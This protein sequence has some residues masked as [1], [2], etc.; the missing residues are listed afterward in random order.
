MPD[1]TA[2]LNVT[3]LGVETVDAE[4]DVLVAE[5]MGRTA[6]L[7]LWVADGRDKALCFD[8]LVTAQVLGTADLD[9]SILDPV[10][11]KSLSP[12]TSVLIAEERSC[13]ST[14]DIAIDTGVQASL[15]VLLVATSSRASDLDVYL[16]SPD[17]GL[18]VSAVFSRD[19]D[20]VRVSLT[21]DDL[22]VARPELLQSLIATL[23]FRDQPQGSVTI[24]PQHVD[25]QGIYHA[26]WLHPA[27]TS[28]MDVRIVG[29][30]DTLGAVDVA[31]PVS[32]E[33]SRG[34][35]IVP[36]ISPLDDQRPRLE[37]VGTAREVQL[38]PAPEEVETLD[39]S[40]EPLL[41]SLDFGRVQPLLVGDGEVEYLGGGNRLLRGFGDSF[42]FQQKNAA[43]WGLSA[44][45]T[46]EALGQNLLSN[47]DFLSPSSTGVPIGWSVTASSS[48]TTIP[49][50]EAV[51]SINAAR[52]RAFGSG[53]YVGPKNYKLSLNQSVGIT[54]PTLFSVLAKTTF[55]SAVEID[56]LR[57]VVSLRD[58]L[59]AEVSQVIATFDPAV[60]DDWTLLANPI[61]SLPGGVTQAR[62]SVEMESVETS[63][64]HVLYCM[65]PNLQP[66]TSATS[67]IV[68]ALPATRSEDTVRIQQTGNIEIPRGSVAV[69]F[70]VAHSG[71]PG[72]DTCLFDT[73]DVLGRDGFAAFH[74]TTGRLQFIVAG[75]VTDTTV[76]SA[77]I[78]FTTGDA[79]TVSCSWSS[80]TLT[81]HHDDVEVASQSGAVVLPDKLQDYVYFFRTTPDTNRLDGQLQTVVI[82]RDLVT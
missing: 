45:T 2:A 60:L 67:S 36:N 77:P 76:D 69:T 30:V 41:L 58:A 9:V 5:P 44:F 75:P 6:T 49:T 68:G 26:A 52:I 53:S 32:V 78:S 28:G 59:D 82:E 17:L 4:A 21:L 1:L 31:V 27:H 42:M 74:L 71:V 11:T 81:I 33:E 18:G 15:D 46:I 35:M 10:T 23:R 72:V 19:G 29:V 22:G 56:D 64:D 54:G 25:D 73:R 37:N 39:P 63:D 47:S 14:L 7:D 51:G 62:V 8:V 40:L 80:D 48:V 13:P 34:S 57:L 70:A 61:T 20:E 55:G 50:L 66:G 24:E 79:Q 12:E 65:A 43:P 3:V 16:R 38:D